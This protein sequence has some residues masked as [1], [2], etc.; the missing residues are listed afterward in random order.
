MKFR[1][2]VKLPR[3][4]RFDFEP[5]YYDPVKEEVEKRERL[6]KGAY[7][8]VDKA[9][10]AKHRISD[11]FH[12]RQRDNRKPV[13]RQVVIAIAISVIMVIALFYTDKLFQ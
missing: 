11:A 9:E 2:F 7:K 8:N 12:A 6:I 4:K 1:S 10:R 3:Y 13:M 5:R